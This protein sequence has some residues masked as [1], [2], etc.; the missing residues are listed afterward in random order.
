[1]LDLYAGSGLMALE[2]LSRKA[3]QVM[4]IEKNH[5]L[6]LH[7]MDIRESWG[8]KD[9]WQIIHGEASRVI[10]N[11]IAGLDFQLIFADPP[12][13]KGIADQIPRWLSDAGIRAGHLVIEESSLATPDWPEGWTQTACRYYGDTCLYFIKQESGS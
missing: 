11:R 1:M 8:L 10:A 4:S 7:M 3:G 12:Y 5:R 6:C 13:D 9:H 2:C